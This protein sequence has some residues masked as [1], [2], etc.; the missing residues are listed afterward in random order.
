MTSRA[1]RSLTLQ[2]VAK[3]QKKKIVTVPNGAI[4]RSGPLVPSFA[5]Q[6][7]WFLGQMEG[8]GAA[9]HIPLGL[10]LRGILD[11]MALQR[12]LDVLVG[13]HEALRTTFYTIDG[14]VYQR[15]EAEDVGFCLY[16]EDLSSF[17]DGQ[18]RLTGYVREEASAP[19][20]LEHGPLIRGRL[21]RTGDEEHVL[22]ITMHHIVSDGWS[23][24]VLTR[25]LSALYKAFSRGES[26]P[27]PPLAI[28]YA[29]YAAW[30]RQWLSGERLA[31]QSSYW[32]RT[33][34]DAP[35]V[36]D[37]P[38]DRRRPV[39]QDFSGDTVPLVLDEALTAGLQALSRRHGL[40][41]FMTVLAGWALVLSRLS[42]QEEVVIGTPSADRG[43][44]EIEGLI[45][46]FINTLALRVDL[47][48]SPTVEQ[49]LE[50]V[51][52]TA[53]EAQANQD[54]PF[55][56]VVDLIKPIRSLNHTPIFQVMFVWQGNE[57]GG[58]LELLGLQ[59]AGIRGGQPSAKFDLTLDLREVNGRVV[60][61]L[62]YATALF[63]RETI[64]RWSGYLNKVLSE[65]VA[66][67]SRPAAMLPLLS[68]A[69]R[70]QLLI[71]WNAT[72]AEYPKDKCIHELFEEQVSRDPAATAVIY[73][74]QSLTYGELNAR[75]NRL[76]HHLR[77]LGV[78]PDAPVAICV[79]R[80]LEMLVGLLAILKA[81]GC[82]VPLDPEY[83]AERLA[84]M[85][86]D[87][88]PKI[89]LT[90]GAARARL[91]LAFDHTRGQEDLS[92]HQ[93]RDGLADHAVAATSSDMLVLDLEADANDWAMYPAN[94]PEPED[95][96]LTSK[97][98]AYI[99][100]TS[101]STGEPK[102][103][104]VEHGNVARLFSATRDW[105]HFGDGDTWSLFH[106]FAF[107][108]S[109][110]E[111]WGALLH[112]G[113]LVVVPQITTRS[114]SDFYQLVCDRGITV[115]NQ[116]PSAFRS[117]MSAQSE[118]KKKH[119]LRGVIFG[120][121]ALE[122]ATVLPW[123]Q[124]TRNAQAQ[125]VNMYG[126]TETTVHVTY[127]PISTAPELLPG[128]YA[129]N[130][131]GKRIPD[132][133]IYLLDGFGNPV[134]RGV[135]GEIYIGGA[136]VARGYLNRAD[137]TSERFIESPFVA[138]DRLYKTGDLGRY[139]ADGNI[140]FLGRN[141]F[142]VKI[143]G[144][145]IELGE[146]EARLTSYPGVREA[147][148][149]A[150][151][152]EPGDKRLVAYYTVSLRGRD[153]FLG[154]A[155]PGQGAEG[156]DIAVP[157]LLGA[158]TLRA[159]LSSV[160]PDYMVPV[161]YVRLDALPLTANG[162]LDRKALPAPQGDAYGR[163]AYEAAVGSIETALAEI[164][165]EVLGVEKVGRNDSFFDL[166][167]HS[168]LAIRVLE[169]MR[170]AGLESDVRSLFAAPVLSDLAA[171]IKTVCGVI[172]P[173]IGAI[174]R[175]G[176]LVPSF[177][178]QRLWFLG[179]IEGVSAAYHIPLGLRLSGLLD[180]AALQRSLDVLV[181]RHEALR[182]TLYD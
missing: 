121:E 180:E 98:L 157:D 153:R 35:A 152:D 89:V 65:M 159:Y 146:I 135:T 79:E 13:R 84:F 122:I 33:L 107:D 11:E 128:G 62:T 64:E 12:S 123:Y 169:R 103:V 160:L 166:G 69:E 68:A 46:L 168:L 99:I 125:L 154:L 108:F 161:A 20:D 52:T 58:A 86:K 63:D 49:L 158:E 114:P 61:G 136:G 6:R 5:Q 31:E 94:N 70:N 92:G 115:L 24:G 83:P 41:L 139:L 164:W 134:P 140:E 81:G 38:A 181:G 182:T 45:G 126:I 54:L 76:A 39:Q 120:G 148:V 147:V 66:D 32:Q 43:R 88:N 106:S 116:T 133:R 1:V 28:Q 167:G 96:G 40:T 124:D 171:R 93:N 100:Y 42:N 177:A 165:A 78:K 131:I 170:R 138:G 18:D 75:A 110:W 179:Q 175:S 91:D 149:L 145:R 150:R 8:V 111:L 97:N 72:A 95:I 48:G 21:I 151:E 104:M 67:A 113:E 132:L 17:A 129:V 172:A 36:I 173:P 143:R 30:Q 56:Q 82:Y 55:E 71:E 47:S 80:S 117:F 15:I 77:N 176:P 57:G 127:H 142:Q 7:L 73:E 156:C 9:Y 53:L 137:L 118:N 26:D 90:H 174:D 85:L 4:D 101:G 109:V 51:K 105:F 60:G 162:K 23:M 87:A 178:Q 112:G 74:D 22:L 119:H 2:E 130:S 59:V 3:L 27:L 19:F 14:E 50:R 25:E 34:A 155:G 144:F 44:L 10:R 141:D 163:G 29:D 16:R 102:G 37:L